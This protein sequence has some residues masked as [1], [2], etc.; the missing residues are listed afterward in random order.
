MARIL[1]CHVPKDGST[2]RELGGALMG[3][4]HFV[5]FDGEPDAH[6]TD[7]STRLR[8]FEAVVVVWTE[9][10]YQSAGLTQIA[11]ETLPLN[12]LIPVR[13]ET[14]EI[15]R[16]PLAYRK[17]NMF[18]PRDFDGLARLIARLST[19]ATSLKEMAEHA[20]KFEAEPR[21]ELP[22]V[23]PKPARKLEPPP[24]PE[25]PVLAPVHAS[26]AAH[27]AATT[28]APLPPPIISAAHAQYTVRTPVHFEL[29]DVSNADDMDEEQPAFA[30]P[31]A[32]PAYS[33][34]PAKPAYSSPP[35]K[36]AYST[37]PAK[38][39]YSTVPAKPAYAMPS[40]QQAYSRPSVQPAFVATRA[41]PAVSRQAEPA[42]S[43]QA[44]PASFVKQAQPAT[45]A[46]PPPQIPPQF[47]PA[48]PAPVPTSQMQQLRAASPP[49]MQ[50]AERHVP[51]PSPQP[52]PPSPYSAI[53][54]AQDLSAAVE[55]GLLLHYIPEMM[56]LG[57]PGMVEVRLDRNVLEEYFGRTDP[58]IGASV[59]E[60]LSL[61][62]YGT[63]D[64]FEIERLS[65][66]TQFVGGN[67]VVPEGLD[68]WAWQVTPRNP[69][70]QDLVVRVSALLLDRHG[71]PAPVALPDRRFRVDV[72]VRE[73]GRVMSS[74]SGWLRR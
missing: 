59:I 73:G 50:N 7:R 44:Q 55:A 53:T 63:A 38:P 26:A 40:A 39:A 57:E 33:S 62:L 71:V 42:V 4:G 67:S 34:P 16:L 24:L 36:P 72:D 30:A 74:L 19:A 9:A 23:I 48:A 61:S 54:N 60:T 5:S 27:A 18:A 6:R 8:Q 47:A 22:P 52:E 10:S 1:I 68:R 58:A 35:A 2:A 65:E 45:A 64:A 56:W 13:S 37:Q 3:R 43:R 29:P 66:R 11:R 51:A 17:L 41:E 49:K 15:G 69:G 21:R 20:A 31:P 25:E 28:H 70:T 32:K 12:L 14:L 46:M